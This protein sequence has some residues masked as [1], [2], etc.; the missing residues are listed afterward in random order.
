MIRLPGNST[1]GTGLDLG[2]S[3]PEHGVNTVWASA[4]RREVEKPE[5][6]RDSDFASIHDGH[7]SSSGNVGDEVGDGHL[8]T[9]EES[10]P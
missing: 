3:S 5:A 10:D 6:E 8:A 2:S 4:A 9:G 7:P 1:I